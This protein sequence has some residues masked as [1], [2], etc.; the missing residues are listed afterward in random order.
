VFEPNYECGFVSSQEQSTKYYAMEYNKVSFIGNPKE[1]YIINRV[2]FDATTNATL[3]YGR[4]KLNHTTSTKDLMSIFGPS[5]QFDKQP[6]GTTITLI[7]ELED[8]LMFV[9]LIAGNLLF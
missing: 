8:G 9:F 7:R 4:W 5:V 1:N 6:N 3:N 2:K